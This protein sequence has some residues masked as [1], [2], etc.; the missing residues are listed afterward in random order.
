MP[1]IWSCISRK[2]ILRLLG[3]PYR[4]LWQDWWLDLS[5]NKSE[6]MVFSRK[7]EVPQVSVRLGQTALRNVTEV[8]YLGIIFDRK[9]TW[10]LTWKLEDATQG[11]ILWK[12]LWANLGVPTQHV[13]WCF[14]KVL[15]GLWRARRI[16]FGLMRS[17]HVMSVEVLAGLPPIRQR[18][19][20][21]NGRFLVLALVKPND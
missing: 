16:C 13:Y 3:T 10:R 20:F 18:L 8:K 7:H 2:S 11:L 6:M 12:A 15:S 19:L 17:T 5:A 1:M 21:L 4:R 9:L 14:I